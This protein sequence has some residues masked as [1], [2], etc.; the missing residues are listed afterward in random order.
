MVDIY[1]HLADRHAVAVLCGDSDIRCAL[2]FRR[3]YAAHDLRYRRI[4]AR[5]GVVLVI[6]VGGDN[7]SGEHFSLTDSEFGF[8]CAELDA[9]HALVF[10]LAVKCPCAVLVLYRQNAVADGYS[11]AVP[12]A[13]SVRISAAGRGLRI[14]AESCDVEIR[15]LYAEAV[16]RLVAALLRGVYFN[17]GVGI[18]EQIPHSARLSVAGAGVSVLSTGRFH[19]FLIIDIKAAAAENYF[20]C[21]QRAFP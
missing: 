14:G 8:R 5:P 17:R 4:V 13:L 12:V 10:F 6:C 15:R 19:E 7:S 3:D 9:R 2:F 16:A 18:V 1:R 11:V 21:A 20:I